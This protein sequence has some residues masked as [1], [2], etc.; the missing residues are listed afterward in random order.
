MR[1]SGVLLVVGLTTCGLHSARRLATAPMSLERGVSGCYV[2]QTQVPQDSVLFALDSAMTVTGASERRARLLLLMPDVPG[3]RIIF[4]HGLNRW[5]IEQ[6]S[7]I[8]VIWDGFAHDPLGGDRFVFTV[9]SDSLVGRS[10]IFSNRRPTIQRRDRFVARR[11][12][13]A[14]AT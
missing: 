4:A 2:V 13:C 9:F 8:V 14:R 6:D 10:E 5:Y 12:S 7:L 11:S 3:G 1:L